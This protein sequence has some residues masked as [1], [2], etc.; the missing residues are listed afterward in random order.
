MGKTTFFKKKTIISTVRFLAKRSD[1]FRDGSVMCV[2]NNSKF[3]CAIETF[4]K[5]DPI[6]TEHVNRTKNVMHTC[7]LLSNPKFDMKL[8]TYW[9][10]KKK[11]LTKIRQTNNDVLIYSTLAIKDE[12]HRGL[13]RFI[14]KYFKSCVE[15][16][17]TA[18]SNLS[19]V[20][21]EKLF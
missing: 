1:A 18:R 2:E 14:K 4:A 7:P 19:S 12:F 8:L 15:T 5:F 9:L 6:I 3:V 13:R 10:E 20:D 11:N 21:V 16:K 17:L